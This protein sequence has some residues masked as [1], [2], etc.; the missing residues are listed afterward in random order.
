[1]F[2]IFLVFYVAM[3]LFIAFDTYYIGIGR[4]DRKVAWVLARDIVSN[5]KPALK[6]GTR[7]LRWSVPP[8]ASILL[9]FI[10]VNTFSDKF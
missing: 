2:T 10:L 5:W 3:T 1:V 8:V 7:F 4:L 6:E 9:I